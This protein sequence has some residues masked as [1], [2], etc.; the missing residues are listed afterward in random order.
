MTAPTRNLAL[1]VIAICSLAAPARASH[2]DATPLL[3]SGDSK[4]PHWV[5]YAF[6]TDG[7]KVVAD[8]ESQNVRRPIQLGYV[9]YDDQ[10]KAI[11]M[12]TYSSADGVRGVYV[13]ATAAGRNIHVDETQLPMKSQSVSLTLT[14]NSGEKEPVAGTYKL[15]MWSAGEADRHSHALRGDQ[16]VSC[17]GVASGEDTFIH[18]S[19]DFEGTATVAAGGGGGAAVRANFETSREISAQ[20]TLVGVY[21][22]SASAVDEMSVDTPKGSEECPC[23]FGSFVPDI[24]GTPF[25]PGSY[26]FRDTGSGTAGGEGE[27][28]LAGADARL[29]G[30]DGAGSS[31]TAG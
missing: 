7:G 6:S 31:C 19:R 4:D 5:S 16:G 11:F 9:V 21:L 24:L 29:V 1:V 25:G 17:I 27:I 18:T 12:F 8:F 14:M 22:S 26:T 23:Q 20:G 30:L 28:I 15:L 10:N 3:D 13:D 2:D